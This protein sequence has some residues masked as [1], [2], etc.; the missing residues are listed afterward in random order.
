M[1]AAEATGPVAEEELGDPSV[2][3]DDLHVTYRL[4]GGRR[5]VADDDAS[6]LARL[7]SRSRNHLG[8]VTEVHAVRGVSFVARHGEAIGIIGRNGSGKSTLLRA[9]AGL[10]P[11]ASG[12]VYVAGRTALLGVSAAL[13]KDLT[14]ERNIMLG[15]LALGLSPQQVRARFDD[16]VEFAGIGDSVHLPMSSYSSGMGARL[17]FA[18]SASAAPDILMIDEALATGDAEFRA[19]SQDKIDEIR[20]QAGTVF[21]VSHSDAT[22]RAMCGRALWVDKGRLVRDGPVDE[23]CDAYKRSAK[24]RRPPAR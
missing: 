8:G 7:V 12:A 6:R 10:L 1:V 5:H 21:L 11:P 22:V 24:P 20:E 3:V 18:I 2:V 13:M 4:Y 9:V 14:G 23:V 17:R 15:G 16:V 19:R